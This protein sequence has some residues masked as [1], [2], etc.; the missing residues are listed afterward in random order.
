MYIAKTKALISCADLRL[1]H[2]CKKSRF[3]HDATQFRCV[4]SRE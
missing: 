4:S 1:F 3:S 2:I